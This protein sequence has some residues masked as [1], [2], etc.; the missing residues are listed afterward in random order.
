[1]ETV[2]AGCREKRIQAVIPILPFFCLIPERSDLIEE[3]GRDLSVAYH[4][5]L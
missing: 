4:E 1:M 2:G 5:A 3:G